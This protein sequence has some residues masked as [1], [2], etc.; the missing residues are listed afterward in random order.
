MA[1]MAGLITVS[2]NLFAVNTA[3]ILLIALVSALEL[4]K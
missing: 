4:V 1:S 2:C 3:I